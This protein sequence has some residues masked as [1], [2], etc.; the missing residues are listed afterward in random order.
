MTKP[1]SLGDLQLAIM[2][3]LWGRGEATVA[4]VHGALE[5]ERGLAPTTISTMLSKMEDKGVVV[6]RTEGRKYVYRP[7]VTETEVRRAM[8]GEL[9]ERLF[10]GNVAAVVNTLLDAHDVDPDEL[11]RMREL[12]DRHDAPPPSDRPN[13]REA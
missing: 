8:L 6:H 1:H 4:D 10:L 9:T 3:V 2:R 13:D 7:T 5:P 12:I 11:A